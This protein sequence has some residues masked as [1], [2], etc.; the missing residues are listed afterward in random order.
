MEESEAKKRGKDT[1]VGKL[2]HDML[3]RKRVDKC[4]TTCRTLMTQTTFKSSTDKL[5]RQ[6]LDWGDMMRSRVTTRTRNNMLGDEGLSSEGT[7]LNSILITAKNKIFLTDMEDPDAAHY[8]MLEREMNTDSTTDKSLSSTTVQYATQPKAP[9]DK[10]GTAS[11]HSQTS[12]GESGKVKGYPRPNKE[13][14]SA[15]SYPISSVHPESALGSDT[16]EHETLV[17]ENLKDLLA[18][19]S[20]IQS[21]GKSDSNVESMPDDEILSIYEDNDEEDDSDRELFVAE[22]VVIDH[23]VDEYH[24][25]V[26]KEDTHT[27][28][29]AA[30]TK[31]VSFMFVTQSDLVSSPRDV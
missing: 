23:V 11:N 12:L 4:Q 10:K 27:I 24:T 6:I 14:V 25:K 8:Q 13:L 19:H 21:L 17:D 28:V 30:T 3:Q 16:L 29:S 18:I 5:A 22:G 15:H 26:N 1:M 7:K 20:G 9:T 31:E 2:S